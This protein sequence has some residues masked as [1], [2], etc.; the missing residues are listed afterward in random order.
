[1]PPTSALNAEATPEYTLLPSGVAKLTATCLLLGAASAHLLAQVFSSEFF[2]DP[3]SEGWELSV[4][5]CEPE[6]LE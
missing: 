1:V 2:S 6:R 4:E 3:V 5:Y